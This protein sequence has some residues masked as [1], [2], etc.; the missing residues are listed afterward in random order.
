MI[1]AIHSTLNGIIPFLTVK[2]KGL[3]ACGD[4]DFGHQTLNHK[5]SAVKT[6]LQ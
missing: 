5:K 1:Y 6:A 2:I 3:V 4:F